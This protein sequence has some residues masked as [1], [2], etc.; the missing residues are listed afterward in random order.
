MPAP[1]LES[2]K[3]A[4]TLAELDE[5]F[6][7]RSAIVAVTASGQPLTAETGALRVVLAEETQHRARRI[8]ELITVRLLRTGDAAACCASVPRM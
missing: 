4:S 6:A 1:A 3:V 7:R 5:Q 8:R 2:Y